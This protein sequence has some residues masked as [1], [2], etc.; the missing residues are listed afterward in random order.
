[1]KKELAQCKQENGRLLELLGIVFNELEDYS[2]K[3]KAIQFALANRSI[4]DIDDPCATNTDAE[5]EVVN[6][7]LMI[8]D[9]M[10]QIAKAIGIDEIR[11]HITINDLLD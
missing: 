1:M 3:I 10:K 6:L 7:S 8:D 4:I 2:E 11:L 9:S 5:R